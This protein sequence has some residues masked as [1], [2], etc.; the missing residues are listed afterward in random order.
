[1][2]LSLEGVQAGAGVLVGL[3]VHGGNIADSAIVSVGDRFTMDE[4]NNQNTRL[5]FILDL[6]FP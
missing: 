1:M 2:Q 5:V 4:I 3:Q 6:L